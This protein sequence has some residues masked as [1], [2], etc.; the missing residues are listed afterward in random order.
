MCLASGSLKLVWHTGRTHTNNVAIA[1]TPTMSISSW[2]G[3]LAKV[4]QSLLLTGNSFRL[5]VFGTNAFRCHCSLARRATAIA[6]SPSTFWSL[7]RHRLCHRRCYCPAG[8]LVLSRSPLPMLQP[9][10]SLLSSAGEL[11][12]PALASSAGLSPGQGLDPCVSFRNQPGK[13]I[14]PLH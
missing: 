6:R 1:H 5:L 4:F 11:S 7:T 14:Q 3:T 8:E 13:N 2:C 9:Q 12:L 10:A